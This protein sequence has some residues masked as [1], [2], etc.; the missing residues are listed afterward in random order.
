MEG[1]RRN[2]ARLCDRRFAL[3][4]RKV[5]SP[6]LFDKVAL[7]RKGTLFSPISP[8][9]TLCNSSNFRFLHF[10]L[11]LPPRLLPTQSLAPTSP[12]R[13]RRRPPVIHNT[14]PSGRIHS[15]MGNSTDP[16]TRVG[17][18]IASAHRQYFHNGDVVLY[19]NP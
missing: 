11:S 5:V 4:S 1:G 3:Y 8:G 14:D 13:A 10:V 18:S 15:D 9:R 6:L 16:S 2:I 7:F 17:P 19:Q 12:H